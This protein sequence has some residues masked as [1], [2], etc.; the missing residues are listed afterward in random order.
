MGRASKRGF[1]ASVST[2]LDEISAERFGPVGEAPAGGLRRLWPGEVVEQRFVGG[3][4]AES[5]SPVH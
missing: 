3:T 4:G 2:E 1:V 5:Y